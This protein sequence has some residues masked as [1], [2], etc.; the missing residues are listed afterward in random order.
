MTQPNRRHFPR[1]NEEADIQVLITPDHFTDLKDRSDFIPAKMVNQSEDG[2]YIEI[3]RALQP[4]S[5]VHF[6]MVGPGKDHPEDAYFMNDGRVVW[7]NRIDKKTSRFGV[8][9]KI[10]NKF[11][12]AKILTSR[13]DRPV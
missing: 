3:D 6:K 7:C 12:Q 4:G 11:V 9:V 2:L 13:L 5:D 8:G 1:K 10:L